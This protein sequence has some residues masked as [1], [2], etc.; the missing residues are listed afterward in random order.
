MRLY[1]SRKSWS[2]LFLLLAA[3][4]LAFALIPSNPERIIHLAA[5]PA[6]VAIGTIARR[7]MI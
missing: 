6:C 7:R 3:I 2:N 1:M 4:N 5:I